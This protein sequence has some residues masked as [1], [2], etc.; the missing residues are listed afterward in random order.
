MLTVVMEVF[1]KDWQVVR[2]ADVDACA[3]A[4]NKLLRAK[5]YNKGGKGKKGS[6]DT[7]EHSHASEDHQELSDVE[8][9]AQRWRESAHRSRSR[10][11]ARRPPLAAWRPCGG[12][13]GG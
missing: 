7:P 11:P 10:S 13:G 4:L 1:D 2:N 3:N 8:E 12:V 9:E 5:N 6:K